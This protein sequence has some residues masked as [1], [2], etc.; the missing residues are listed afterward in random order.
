MRI[1]GLQKLTLLDFPGKTA[2]TVFTGGCNF[3]CPF[4]Q[5][6]DLVFLPKGLKEIELKDFFLFLEKRKGL[7]DGVCI[8]GG[9]PLLQNDF[10]AFCAAIKRLGYLVK[11]DTNG[12]FPDRLDH[13]INQGMV[14]YVAMDIKN[15]PEHYAE[16]AGLLAFDISPVLESV[17][18][19]LRGKVPYEFR[20]TVVKEYHTA[21]RLVSA[22]KWLKGA[23][24]Y[25][26]QSFVASENVIGSGLHAYQ[27]EQLEAFVHQ[28]TPYIANTYLRGI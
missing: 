8:S 21:E 22:A 24:R 16:T 9:E 5:N 12:S 26:L 1:Y 17:Q 15:A 2:C 11:L 3:R 10:E 6:A 27:K 25:F 4:C 20:T 19:L 18:I 28:I 7:L 14:D 23:E 13:L